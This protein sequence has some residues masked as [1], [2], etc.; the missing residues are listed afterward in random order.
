VLVNFD[1][2]LGILG[3][4]GAPNSTQNVG[5]LDQRM[6]VE[7]VRDN[8]EAFGGDAYKITIFGHSAGGVSVD[9]YNY[10]WADD[11]IIVNKQP[12]SMLLPVRTGRLANSHSALRVE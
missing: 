11:P 4:S 1:Y 7:W 2:R 12:S 3:F 10:A 9:M 8:I 5:L 6:A